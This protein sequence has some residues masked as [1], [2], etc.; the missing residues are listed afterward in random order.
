MPDETTE[1]IERLR[2]MSNEIAVWREQMIALRSASRAPDAKT[3]D[4]LLL[5]VEE[6]SGKIY[7]GIAEFD[8]LLAD[9][10]R[11]SHAAAAQI[12]EVGD[13]LRLILMEITELGTQLYALRSAPPQPGEDT[14]DANIAA[15]VAEDVPASDQID[16]ADAAQAG[17]P[18]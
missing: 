18:H 10:D 2:L 15:I 8:A 6:T 13:A 5:H 12:V 11:K 16:A 9:I 17:E 4:K 7:E 14:A 3:D 1:L